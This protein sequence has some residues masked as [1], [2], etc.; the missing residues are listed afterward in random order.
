LRNGQFS[1]TD[2]KD[3]NKVL[4]GDFASY[5][6]L[7]PFF[8]G[9]LASRKLSPRELSTADLRARLADAALPGELSVKY[10]IEIA[11]RLAM[12][13]APLVF[14]LLGAP[15][16]VVLEKK[17]RS[18][19]FVFSLVI[20]FFYYGFSITS[21]VLARKYGWLFPWVMFAPAAAGAALGLWMWR[22]RLFAR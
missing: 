22:K 2:Y 12:A 4:Y 13:L 10:R 5:K 15:L 8:S 14:F 6:T 7:I 3:P 21:M 16:G 9:I 1:Q 19:G 18:A 11:S 20:I 17:S